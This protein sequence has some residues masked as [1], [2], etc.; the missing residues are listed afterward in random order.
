LTDNKIIPK[1]KDPVNEFLSDL[2]A[3]MPI[4]KDFD[5]EKLVDTVIAKDKF[6]HDSNGYY[7]DKQII[8]MELGT[9]EMIKE[10]FENSGYIEK[11]I[12]KYKLTER[13]ISAKEL[14]GHKQFLIFKKREIRSKKAEQTQK[15]YFYL[16]ILISILAILISGFMSWLSY[17]LSKSKM[18]KAE[19]VACRLDTLQKHIE[20]KQQKLQSQVDSI[21]N[22]FL[23]KQKDTPTTKQKSGDKN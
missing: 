2:F 8:F 18:A 10:L 5:F 22:L 17:D 19:D 21:S 4:G 11:S 20:L 3:E 23:S 9:D 1:L 7:I 13:G 14:G 12:N 6:L 16:P 15:I